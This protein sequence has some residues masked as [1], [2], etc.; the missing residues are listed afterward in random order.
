MA[1]SC[2]AHSLS[3]LASFSVSEQLNCYAAL[4]HYLA[5][6]VR[7]MRRKASKWYVLQFSKRRKAR[8]KGGTG[9]GRP[10]RDPKG[11]KCCVCCNSVRYRNVQGQVRY[12]SRL[13][14]PVVA[15][16]EPSRKLAPSASKCPESVPSASTSAPASHEEKHPA[17]PV[18]SDPTIAS[19]PPHDCQINCPKRRNDASVNR[20]ADN[21]AELPS[22]GPYSS[23]PVRSSLKSCSNTRKAPKTSRKCANSRR[24][25][26]KLA[27]ES[28]A[29]S[30][31]D[32][33]QISSPL[34]KSHSKSSVLEKNL[35]EV[36]TRSGSKSAYRANR[37]CSAPN[38]YSHYY[39]HHH[40]FPDRAKQRTEPGDSSKLACDMIT[41]IKDNELH[42]STIRLSKAAPY[43]R[44]SSQGT[45]SWDSS[46][47]VANENE[48]VCTIEPEE[49]P[50]RPPGGSPT[51]QHLYHRKPHRN[52]E[53]RHHAHHAH[54][55]THHQQRNSCSS[56]FSGRSH[57]SRRTSSVASS[58]SCRKCCPT[59]HTNCLLMLW[60]RFRKVLQLITN[61]NYFKRAIFLAI[62]FN[63]FAMGIESHNQPESL[64]HA[65]EISNAI[66]TGKS[67]CRRFKGNVVFTGMPFLFSHFLL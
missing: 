42:N 6:L 28:K 36:S 45:I 21:A 16:P 59:K 5:H 11:A 4:I 58:I 29:E 13:A 37:H 54:H 3:T 1:P 26:C 27:N 61:H 66:F 51:Q 10:V 20:N 35:S 38:L 62:L 44:K 48:V 15:S 64:T 25:N 34:L 14:A 17:V 24:G 57:L 52:H 39:H 55:H 46:S 31:C 53:H 41:S 40:V 32:L 9:D 47:F 63:T 12:S 18:P 2:R 33:L 56:V 7:K 23:V 65:V 19:P 8:H 50:R 30:Q 49:L 22:V 67:A 60:S 43:Q